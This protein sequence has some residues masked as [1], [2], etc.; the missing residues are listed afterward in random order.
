MSR[1][2]QQLRYD[3]GPV[4]TNPDKFE[5][6][7]FTK[8]DQMFSVHIVFVS[9][10]II[11]PSTL[12]RINLKTIRS[13]GLKGATSRFVHLEK[14]SLNFSS[15]SFAI[16]FNLDHPRP[17]TFRFGL[18]LPIWCLSILANYYFKVSLLLKEIFYVVKMTPNIV[19]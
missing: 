5:N 9:F 1:L 16:R 19:T 14:F 15:S 13:I 8:T 6:G 11:S 3:L 7:V 4:H 10:S 18:F 17:S 2:R 12:I